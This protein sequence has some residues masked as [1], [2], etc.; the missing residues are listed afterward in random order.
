MQEHDNIEIRSE[1]VQEILGT[2]PPWMARFGTLLALLVVVVLGYI[3]YF[4]EYPVVVDAGITVSSKEP[5][6]RLVS[7]ISGRVQSILVENEA[8]VKAND[9]IVVFK[10]NARLEDMLTLESKMMM[11]EAPTDSALL[12]FSVPD[13]FVLG[14][15]KEPLYDFYRQQKVRQQYEEN[16]YDKYSI[17][18]LEREL[19]KIQSIIRS[20]LRRIENLDSQIE[21]VQ[22]RLAREEKLV[23][24]NLLAESRIEKTRESLLSLQRMREGVESS[25]KNRELEK[26]RIRAEKTG[27]RE[28][29][30]ESKKQAGIEL[31]ER[32][33]DLQ[34]AVEE[35]MFKYVITAPVAGVVS[36]YME[37][38]TEQQFVEEGF[39]IGVV[40]PQLEQE[41]K[42]TIWL[43][44]AK[45]SPVK[46]GKKV[47]VSFD[48]YPVLEF[49]STI[50]RVE[51]I[52]QVPINGQVALTI[53]F[54]R[55]LVTEFGREL[56]ASQ[57]MKG[58]ANIIIKDKRFIERIFEHFRG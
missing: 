54:P 11:M 53:D 45:A 17:D 8:A 36:L 20:D 27:V 10:S 47:V 19:Q 48:V 7:N 43:P 25:I 23:R 34:R 29:S 24:D 9:V 38:I 1:E 57:T 46:P 41:A 32:F 37:D 15:I 2:P 51:S 49:G 28:G 26:E 39:E 55:G 33:N 16:P 5:P 35:W 30:V 18:Q 13:T 52:S 3:S 50:G 21:L 6:K 40:V 58:E 12:A 22:E 4:I 31:R 42:G 44:V 56:D 14:S